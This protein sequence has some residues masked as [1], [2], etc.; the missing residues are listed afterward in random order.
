MQAP[1]V[2]GTR[3]KTKASISPIGILPG[4]GMIMPENPTSQ[5]AAYIARRLALSYKR[6]YA[7]NLSK[8]IKRYPKIR[9]LRTG[10]LVT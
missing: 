4:G 9:P 7:E 3:K 10:D 5:Q 6:E 2:N 1:N 8:G